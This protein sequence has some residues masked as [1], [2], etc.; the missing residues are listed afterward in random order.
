[1]SCCNCLPGV[2]MYGMVKLLPLTL[3]IDTT[4]PGA[5]IPYQITGT[6]LK[7]DW[8]DGTIGPS[9][10][11][12]ATP[13]QY[14][15]EVHGG[16]GDNI[17]AG[18]PSLVEVVDFGEYAASGYIFGTIFPTGRSPNMEAV[19]NLLP[20]SVTT[21]NNMFNGATAFNQDIGDWDTAAV[22]TMTQM[23][24]GATAFNQDI[25]DWDTGAV[26]SLQSAFQ[27]ASAFNQDIGDWDT[28]A[29]TNMSS[30]F[31]GA[32]A[33]DQPIGDWDTSAVTGMAGMFSLATLFNQ[34]IGDWDTAAVTNMNSMFNGASTFDQD[35][36]GWCVTLIPT[37]PTNFASNTPAWALP[38][39][40]WGTCP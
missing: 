18:H 13:G 4:L 20:E 8:G 36:S 19:P 34:D 17:T 2:G 35:L 7:I 15:I 31:A 22:T 33:F 40:V 5:E 39:P 24:N 27:G 14:V 25:G 1:M 3:S 16:K 10:H 28:A 12:Y 21:M 6:N 23:F 11:T 30:M 9:P 38:K 29:V 32:T 37:Q 26:I